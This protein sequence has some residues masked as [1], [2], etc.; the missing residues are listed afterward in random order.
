MAWRGSRFVVSR[1]APS[2]AP[3]WPMVPWHLAP[4][5]QPGAVHAAGGPPTALAITGVQNPITVSQ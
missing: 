5:S 1:R 2:I 4:S 3:G